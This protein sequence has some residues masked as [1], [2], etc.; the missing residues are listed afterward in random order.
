MTG[1]NGLLGQKIAVLAGGP[2]S[3]REVSLKSGR[4]VHEALSGLGLDS[5][6]VDPLEG[7]IPALK[8]MNCTAVFI[9]LHG[10]FGEDGTVQGMLEE[11]GLVYTGSG[12]DASDKA[13]DKTKAQAIFRTHGLPTAE[14][15]VLRH[16]SDMEKI[17]WSVPFVVKPAKAGSSVGISIVQDAQDAHRACREAFKHSDEV[18]VERYIHGRELTVGVL[19]D[20]ALPVGEIVVQRPF[21]DY[22]AKYGDFG[23]RY[24]F[25]ASLEE[26]IA[27]KLRS[28]ALRAHRAL[29]CEVMSRVD[30]M[31]SGSG[32][33]F[34]LEV[35]SIPGLT[36]KSLLPKAAMAKGIDFPALC[37]KILDL[38]LQRARSQSWSSR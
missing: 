18:L 2:S 29:G 16:P 9:A 10:Q 28:L 37:V 21:Y 35:N 13:F 32:E 1:T 38:S 12:V 15:T 14:S 7:F 36:D 8:K 26:N 17:S 4:A 24:D 6:L 31:L 30:F 25:P 33:P 20:E 5:R 34:I 23:T 27:A 11:A 3:E 19:G 22:E